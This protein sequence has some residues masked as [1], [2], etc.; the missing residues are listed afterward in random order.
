M[1]PAATPLGSSYADL[2]AAEDFGDRDLDADEA[3]TAAVDG[4][5][6]VAVQTADHQKVGPRPCCPGA[7]AATTASRRM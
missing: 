3:N 4:E 7:V 6:P 5:Q 1:S 2:A